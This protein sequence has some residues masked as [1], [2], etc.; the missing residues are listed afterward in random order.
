MQQGGHGHGQA[1]QNANGHPQHQISSRFIVRDRNSLARLEAEKTF[2]DR[3]KQS[4]ANFGA[5]WLK[6]PGIPKTL[7]QMREECREMDEQKEAERREQAAQELIQA[8][9]IAAGGE[10]GVGDGLTMVGGATE[11]MDDAD[12]AAAAVAS[13]MD[14]DMVGEGENGE[15]EHDLDNEI[16]DADGA[17]FSLGNNNDDGDDPFA[18]SSE[19]EDEEEEADESEHAREDGGSD[20]H[21]AGG[22]QG[23]AD[24]SRAA[25][26]HPFST[27][28]HSIEERREQARARA[29]ERREMREMRATEDRMR[30]MRAQ[31]RL[32]GIG[33]YGGED[34]LDEEDEAEM[35]QEDDLVRA[36]G[37]GGAGRHVAAGS[38]GA[39]T[40]RGHNADRLGTAAARASLGGGSQNHHSHYQIGGPGFDVAFEDDE[41]GSA[42]G[43]EGGSGLEMDMDADLDGDIPEGSSSVVVGAMDLS[44]YE[45][46]YEHT[47]TEAEL[48]SSVFGGNDSL[49]LQQQQQRHQLRH[50]QQQHRSSGGDLDLDIDIDIDIEDMDLPH[51]SFLAAANAASGSMGLAA[52]PRSSSRHFR[53]SMARSDRASL[54]ISSLLSQDGSSNVGSSPRVRR[55]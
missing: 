20:V 14:A 6:P 32:S 17:D 2:Q 26:A 5:T 36:V 24:P 45:G 4:I 31:P 44:V 8:E 35:L 18:S 11:I 13:G 50:R 39:S 41:D 12:E 7:F 37:S 40:A 27:P 46:T 55:L 3:R 38:A 34:D 48:S 28:V 33:M 43:D 10:G 29:A 52:A 21:A 47:D 30:A 15:G 1:G 51:H 25:A 19:E 16:P 22:Q 54:D 42:G 53:S 23:A 9:A 49:Q